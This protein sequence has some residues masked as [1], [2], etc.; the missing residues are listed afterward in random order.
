MGVILYEML[1]GKLP[2]YGGLPKDIIAEIIN[3]DF[4]IPE[5]PVISD[6]CLDCLRRMLDKNPERR[7]SSFDLQYHPWVTK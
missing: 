1:Y 4:E 5:K 6:D 2:F 3:S 7:I